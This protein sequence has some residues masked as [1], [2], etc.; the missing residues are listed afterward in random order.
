MIELYSKDSPLLSPIGLNLPGLRVG[1][2]ARARLLM[3]I[4]APAG[5]AAAYT[6][7]CHVS[8]RR[9]QLL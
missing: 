5:G 7:A 4:R 8:M 2:P 6:L 3:W 9:H 1:Q